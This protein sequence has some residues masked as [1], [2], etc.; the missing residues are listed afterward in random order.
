M[1]YLR[2][3]RQPPA[4]LPGDVDWLV[5]ASRL[6]GCSASMCGDHVCSF[7]LYDGKLV[8]LGFLAL[9]LMIIVFNKGL[10]IA[11]VHALRSDVF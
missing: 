7:C 8:S 3:S 2:E 4:G 10:W 5:T 6:A 11:S 1:S 9:F